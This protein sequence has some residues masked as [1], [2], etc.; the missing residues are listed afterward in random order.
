MAI[1][2]GIKAGRAYVELALKDELVKGLTKAQ[3]RLRAFAAG[4][5][6]LGTKLARVGV[7]AAAPLGLTAKVFGGFQDEMLTVQAVTQATGREFQALTEQAQR[8][9]RTTSFTAK[10]VA[11]GMTALGR[12]GFKA[13]EIEDAIPAV[14]ALARA[15]RTELAAAA[16]YAGSALRA[17]QMDTADTSRVADVLTATANNS[18]QTLD[19]LAEAMKY[20]A[21]VA[22]EAGETIE[23]TAAALGVLA[24]MGIKGSMAGTTVRKVLTSLASPAVR[25]TLR[26]IG[27]AATDAAGNLRPLGKIMVELGRAMA[28]L[29]NARRLSIVKELFGERAIS[30]ALKLGGSAKMFDRL[31]EAIRHSGGVAQR[32]ATQMDSGLGGAMRMMLSA[33]EGAA[34]AIG[35]AL[36]PA[37]TQGLEAVKAA[38]GKTAEWVKRNRALVVAIA[39][40]VAGVLALGVALIVLG[41]LAAGVSAL[42]GVFRVLVVAVKAAKAAMVAYAAAT[43]LAAM[44]TTALALGPL[45]ILAAGF[46]YAAIKAAQARAEMNRLEASSR[47][48]GTTAQHLAAAENDLAS[49][50]K[51]GDLDAQI[52]ALHNVIAARQQLAEMTRD[53][54]GRMETGS[55]EWAAAQGRAKKWEASIKDAQAQLVELQKQR[56]KAGGGGAGG[57]GA[58]GA[59]AE[60]DARQRH[61]L[62]EIEARAIADQYARQIALIRLHYRERIDA[63]REAGKSVVLLE[64][65]QAAEIKQVRAK[66]A[67]DARKEQEA[68]VDRARQRFD[69][70][71]QARKD[72]DHDVARL[73]IRATK[74]GLEQERALLALERDRELA[75]AARTGR[76]KARIREKYAL[77]E[78]L[79]VA[80]MDMENRTVRGTFQ[81]GRAVSGLGVGGGVQERIARATE[82]TAAST[83]RTAKKVD[84][85]G[86]AGR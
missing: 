23:S 74:K 67:A 81:G 38:A 41:K 34:L 85:I 59:A 7:A 62:A 33:A 29:P 54:M 20:V 19:D 13:D 49:A 14:L 21:P 43:S 15:T 31:S 40:V 30:G 83:E 37:I 75:E 3:R 50:R 25:S 64:K 26:D 22:S 45:V 39:K 68:A 73:R 84:D 28:K 71:E 69:A 53:E 27:V 56:R 78:R 82:R 16:D 44:A 70:A 42:I 9:G 58:A 5:T 6:R 86:R 55:D 52:A 4:M 61:Q 51:S 8:L 1:A 79:A 72:L 65:M 24:N 63:A 12:A 60:E 80:R 76:D 48:W 17:F 66:A 35:E 2:D 11:E 18:A 77:M 32:T 47:A 57:P 10:Q 36:A 46:A